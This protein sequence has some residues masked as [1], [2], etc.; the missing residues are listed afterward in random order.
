MKRGIKVTTPPLLPVLIVL[1]IGFGF[2]LCLAAVPYGADLACIYV[3]P[4]DLRDDIYK[5]LGV[6]QREWADKY[7][8]LS[9]R[10]LVIGNLQIIPQMARDIEQLKKEVAALKAAQR[11]NDPNKV[12]K[13]QDK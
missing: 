13:E 1:I 12:E 8:G 7:G 2:L 9:E 11:L 10:T 3:R 4:L 6:P 5:G